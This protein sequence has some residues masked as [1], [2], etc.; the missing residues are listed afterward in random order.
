MAVQRGSTSQITAIKEVTPGTT[1]ATPTML[2]LPVVSFSP[3]VTNTLIR[4]NQIRSHPF[5]DQISRGRVVYDLSTE[6]ELQGTNHDILVETMFGSAISAKSMAFTDALKTLTVEEKVVAG[7]FNSWTYGCF[8]QMSLQVGGS[9]TTPIK[10][11]LTGSAL[12]SALDAASTLATSVTAAASAVPWV[13]VGGSLTL[14][15]GATPVSSASF[16]LNRAMDPL[17]LLGSPNPRELVIGACTAT[18]Q[19]TVPYDAS[20]NASGSTISTAVTGFSDQALTLK[21]T[22]AA[23]TTWRQFAFAKTKFA[24]LDRVLQ[25]R[26]MRMAVVN[27]EAMYDGASTV[28][29]M[30]TQ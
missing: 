2:E 3:K 5:V 16:S 4:S 9:D 23:G 7:V 12:A 6:F 25:S 18:G 22:D 24:G 8:S 11:S 13:F 19:I 17:M 1:P 20:G 15:A 28:C 14:T 21:L 26:G 30:T 27:W 10:V 29:T